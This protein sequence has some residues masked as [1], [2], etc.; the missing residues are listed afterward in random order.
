MGI[1]LKTRWAV[2]DFVYDHLPRARK[3]QR[4]LDEATKIIASL[5][6]KAR[7]VSELQQKLS[8]TGETSAPT[9][10]YTGFS[11]DYP[12]HQAAIDVFQWTTAM[13]EGSGLKA[14]DNNHFTDTRV[15]MAA[16]HIG[17][18]TGKTILELGPYEGY[19]TAQFERA[20]AASVIAIENN[21]DNFLK[22]LVVKNSFG[23][24]S[25][26][27]L[28]DMLKYMHL[29][30]SRF[31]ICWASG[32]L[33]HMTDPISLLEGI[34]RISKSAFI[35]THYYDEERAADKEIG[36]HLDPSRNK[37]IVYKDR[38]ITLHHR[39][40]NH[41]AGS[42][43]SGGSEPFSYWMSKDDIIFCL[44][45]LGFNRIV[46]LVDN[47]AHPPGAATFFLAFAD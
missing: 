33:Y 44:N 29:A 3:L 9:S 18:F 17:G 16:P 35:W 46:S 28:G 34:A 8:Q 4:E 7:E 37:T 40:Y 15:M 21:I 13:P 39:N 36:K 5:R 23:L 10:N 25:T 20:G 2:T 12:G 24:R 43:F 26:F 22:C 45:S 6:P 14:G 31:D 27:L 41:A 42:F 1:L 38:S 19:N 30:D 47:P 32:L 11:S